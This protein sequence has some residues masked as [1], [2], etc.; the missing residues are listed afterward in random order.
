MDGSQRAASTSASITDTVDAVVRSHP[1]LVAGSIVGLGFLVGVA[2]SK[3]SRPPRRL[4]GLQNWA[5]TDIRSRELERTIDR[6]ESFANRSAPRAYDRAYDTVKDTVSNIPETISTIVSAWQNRASSKL[7]EA[8]SA[9]PDVADIK[10]A[11][12]NAAK[13]WAK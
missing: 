1:L 2:I 6:L 8:K 10:S 5:G 13:K 7:D 9:M 4:R 11:A 3:Q 12:V